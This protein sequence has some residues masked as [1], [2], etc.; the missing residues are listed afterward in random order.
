[1]PILEIFFYLCADNFV[2]Q[3]KILIIMFLKRKFYSLLD[4]FCIESQE[5]LIRSA[6]TE[7]G[8]TEEDFDRFL[9]AYLRLLRAFPVDVRSVLSKDRFL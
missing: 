9:R 1:M 3:L 8:F 6:F 7:H 2:T 4:C 5:L